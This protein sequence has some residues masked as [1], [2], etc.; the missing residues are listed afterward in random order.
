MRIEMKIMYVNEYAISNYVLTM[1][2]TRRVS[3]N[4]KHVFGINR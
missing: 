1:K 2:D 3:F 4:N